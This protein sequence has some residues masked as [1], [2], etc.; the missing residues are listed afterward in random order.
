[1]IRKQR[2]IPRLSVVLLLAALVKILVF[3]FEFLGEVGRI[4]V[5]FILG[6]FLIAFSFFYQ[7]FRKAVIERKVRKPAENSQS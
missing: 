3:D 4:I 2:F 5:L 6:G 1:V 7:R